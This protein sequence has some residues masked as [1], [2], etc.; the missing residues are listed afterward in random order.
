MTRSASPSSRLSVEAL[1]EREVPA[2]LFGV[3]TTNVLVTFDSANPSVILRALPITGFL[4]PG[5]VIADIDVRPLTGGIYGFSNLNRMYLISPGTAFAL[6]I[7]N[8]A[9]IAA[10]LK[11]FD[12]D[13]R[14][15]R[16][17][18]IS[19]LGEHQVLEPNFATLVNGGAFPS[20]HVGDPFQGATPRIGGLA[21]SNNVPNANS[22]TLYGID[23]VLNTLVR[24]GATT[25]NDGILTTIGRLGVDVGNRVGFDIAPVSNVAFASLQFA[26]EAFS[27]LSVINLANGRATSLG[28]IGGGLLLSDIAVDT[29]G[30][31]GFASSAGFGAGALPPP[32]FTVSSGFG[33]SGFTFPS[34]ISPFG[35]SVP[36]TP[37][38][39]PLTQPLAGTLTSPLP[40]GSV[41][42]SPVIF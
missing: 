20:Y 42:S 21:F 10:H 39:P 19:N 41:S 32:V 1:E 23:H 16:L 14:N 33:S 40:A 34:L 30:T 37:L 27:R 11:G 29:R 17:R 9:S 31:S 13:P 28:A 26:G 36:T 12:F 35:T 3:T 5:E 38:F 18:I 2:I 15:D 8:P 22:T 6:P 24:V 7:G 4:S 25:L